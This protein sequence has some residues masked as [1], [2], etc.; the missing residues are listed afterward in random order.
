MGK[1]KRTMTSIV[2]VSN[3]VRYSGEACSMSSVDDGVSGPCPRVAVYALNGLPLCR[4]CAT[5][6]AIKFVN[7]EFSLEL[8]PLNYATSV[9]PEDEDGGM[10]W[11]DGVPVCRSDPYMRHAEVHQAAHVSQGDIVYCSYTHSDTMKCGWLSVSETKR[12]TDVSITIFGH[13]DTGEWR[14]AEYPLVAPVVRI[15]A[16]VAQREVTFG[17]G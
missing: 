15:P 8:H 1:A 4:P 5:A 11:I 7:A 16:E 17:E 14:V 3:G 6:G 9:V 10:T 12:Q 13:L 2:Y